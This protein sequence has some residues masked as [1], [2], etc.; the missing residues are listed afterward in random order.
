MIQFQNELQKQLDLVCSN[1]DIIELEQIESV[2]LLKACVLETMRIRP[3]APSG[4][5]RAVNKEITISEYRI[6]KGTM[7]LPLQW[8]M[9]HD[10]KH[11]NDPETFQPKRFLDEEAN[12]INYKAFMPFQAGQFCK[13]FYLFKIKS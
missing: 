3:V 10:E 7:I 1:G 13:S 12:I 2:P 5:P 4:I 8:A 9:H 11:W 6:P